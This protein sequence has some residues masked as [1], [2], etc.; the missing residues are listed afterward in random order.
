MYGYTIELENESIASTDVDHLLDWA[1][2]RL[3][4]DLLGT[5]ETV[6]YG[7]SPDGWHAAF[8]HLSDEGIEVEA[9]DTDWQWASWCIAQS[10]IGLQK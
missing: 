2:R 7:D 9:F 10:R 4:A 1:S 8:S 6:L 5:L 3:D